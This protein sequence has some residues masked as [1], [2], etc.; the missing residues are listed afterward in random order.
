M[1]RPG[2]I[3]IVEDQQRWRKVLVRTLSRRGFEVETAATIEEAR[4]RLEDSFYHLLVLDIRMNEADTGNTDG[5][6]FLRELHEQGMD[7]P[8]MLVMLS[9]YGTPDQMFERIC[10][11]GA[12]RRYGAPSAR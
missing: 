2:R 6:S 9:A 10:L 7:E 12:R 3:L 8:M 4:A 11:E 5:M 1:P